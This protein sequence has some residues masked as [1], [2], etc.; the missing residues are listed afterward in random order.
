M[1][2]THV[3]VNECY[4]VSAGRAESEPGSHHLVHLIDG[5]HTSRVPGQVPYIPCASGS[6]DGVE[7]V[8]HC[9]FGSGPL[10]QYPNVLPNHHVVSSLVTRSVSPGRLERY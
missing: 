8:H 7:P 9:L 1:H 6:P 5:V 4:S 2:F 3:P 10:S